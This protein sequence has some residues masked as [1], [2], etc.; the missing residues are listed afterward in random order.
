MS[1][2][3][4]SATYVDQ[5]GT[6]DILLMNSDLLTNI[7][8]ED[9]FECYIKNDAEMVVAS[10]PYEVSIPYGI[11]E[12]NDENVIQSLHEKP[13]YTYYSNAGI[14]I[15][16][17]SCLKEIPQRSFYNATDLI[18]KLIEENR[19]VVNFAIVDYWLDIGKPK[20]FQKAQ[21]DVNHI[22]F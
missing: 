11:L 17:T 22:Q 21:Q 5:Y 19:R 16:K 20:D 6:S 2:T 7:D 8:F 14:Y 13:T 15:I 3:L 4:G 10:V 1:G 18:E 9:L 12:T